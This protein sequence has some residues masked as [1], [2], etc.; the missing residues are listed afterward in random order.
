[1][2][3]LFC[4]ALESE[5]PHPV[6]FW[7]ILQVCSLI[8][9]I[10]SQIIFYWR[11]FEQSSQIECIIWLMILLFMPHHNF[12]HGNGE[13]KCSRKWFGPKLLGDSHRGLRS[14]S[15]GFC[16]QCQVSW[17]WGVWI[18]ADLGFSA[19]TTGL[20]SR[21][22]VDMHSQASD[23]WDHQILPWPLPTPECLL[24]AMVSLPKI[25]S[26]R[27]NHVTSCNQ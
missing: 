7:G 15:L 19:P 18:L 21:L 27:R 13:R 14:S 24:S 20:I 10:T 22:K 23:P 12:Q 6:V 17:E 5:P 16:S 11:M 1:M 25:S 3:P 26:S 2:S 9:E 8:F 4:S